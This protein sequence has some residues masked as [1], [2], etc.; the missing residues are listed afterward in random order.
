MSMSYFDLFPFTKYCLKKFCVGE[1][2]VLLFSIFLITVY[3]NR[4]FWFEII[5]Y[6]K[7]DNDN[8]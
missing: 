5:S 8:I 1:I 6:C 4:H 2:F 7:R 3:L